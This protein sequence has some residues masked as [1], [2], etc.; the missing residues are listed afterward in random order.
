MDAAFDFLE[1]LGLGQDARE[2][3]IRSAY[4]RRL[5]R[6]D[7]DRDPDAFQQLRAAYETA[8][9]WAAWKV[10]QAEEEEAQ[11]SAHATAADTPPIGPAAVDMAAP[12]PVADPTPAPAPP[13]AADDPHALAHAVFARLNA[14]L[15]VLAATPADDD[16]RFWK[17]ALQR[18]L[19]DPELFNVEARIV[20]EAIVAAVL[21]HGW[22]PGHDSLF[23][24]ARGVFE[25]DH[26]QRR[27][28]QFGQSGA[29]L[30]AA[31]A[32]LRLI[33][34]LAPAERQAIQR[35][36]R[37]LRQPA[38]P[39]T[40]E[41]RALMR[42]VES[43]MARFPALMH[44]TVSI[45][46]VEHWRTRYL[47]LTGM[48]PGAPLEVVGELPA[49]PAPAY[50]RYWNWM[51]VGLLIVFL[52]AL[53]TVLFESGGDPVGY[54]RQRTQ[55][56]NHDSPAVSSAVL[57]A[58]VDPVRFT[59]SAQ[60]KAGPLDTRVRVF[61]DA[62]GKVTRTQNLGTSGEPPFDAAVAQALADARPFPPETPREFEVGFSVT[63]DD[64]AL[65]RAR[66]A[67][68]ESP[69]AALLAKH[70]PPVSWKPTR[71]GREGKLSLRY[72]VFLDAKGKVERFE[73][74]VSSGDPRL[75]HAFEDALRAARPFPDTVAR[76]FEV[77]WS[78]T[79]TRKPAPAE[80]PAP[81]TDG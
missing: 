40:P 61:L 8:L 45:E 33:D 11:Q 10:R 65:E 14:D 24:A 42:N 46:N 56:P 43:M 9:D 3:D 47:E 74:G 37:A 2:R 19:D 39:A 69:S 59:P 77:S 28:L 72:V 64:A 53:L 51:R 55:L 78:T 71:F 7:Q 79:V 38:P 29:L 63:I 4:A 57:R 50:Q 18:R 32:Q 36:A 27:L 67:R 21:A 52:L 20:F 6:I 25:W 34:T 17:S 68:L 13:P 1:L 54:T 73:Q 66:Q 15:D 80:A 26:D 58:H 12:A 60:A 31:I 23:V 49:P 5:K 48:A 62:Q 35:A 44:V 22:R 41:L 75:D 16:A 81:A 30:D 76:S 70:I